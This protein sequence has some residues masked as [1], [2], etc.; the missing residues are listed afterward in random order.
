[1]I[2]SLSILIPTYNNICLKLVQSLQAQAALLYDF[3]Y[4]IIVA[5]DGSTDLSTIEGNRNINK[6]TNCK[7]IERDKNEGRAVIRNFLAKQAKYDW[8]LFIDS[9][10]NVITNDYIAKYKNSN[11]CDVI[12]G[13][14]KIPKDEETKHRLSY[15]LRY[16]F[17]SASPQNGNYMMRKAN[18]YAD[19]H[20]S[21]FMVRRNIIL[22]YPLDE[23]FYHYGY[24]DVL[25]GKTLKLHNIKIE[26][27]DNA[28][29]YEHFIGNMAF[30][31]KT[32]ESLRTLYEFR[33]EL[34]EYSKIIRWAD[35][36]SRCHM[37]SF[38][39]QIFP[40]IS[41]HIKAKLTGNKPNVFLFNI[42]K[43]LYYIHLTK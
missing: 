34:S 42:Y 31:A 19:F 11:P 27:I 36:I 18:P 4:E 10:M 41:L 33:A 24:E 22:K 15:N 39:Q 5:D 17:E 29:G 9:N 35:K 30:V 20:T 21:N 8:L 6:I 26:H 2:N 3:Q 28:L 43:L 13:G 1:M 23:R 12:Y 25:W 16:I 38:C 14:Y 40:L 32:E 37:K 7:Y